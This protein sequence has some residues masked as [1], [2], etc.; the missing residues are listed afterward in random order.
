MIKNLELY[1]GNKGGCDAFG[2]WDDESI[3]LSIS[4]ELKQGTRGLDCLVRKAET[5]NHADLVHAFNNNEAWA[6][7]ED[8]ILCSIEDAKEEEEA[9]ND[10]DAGEQAGEGY[11]G[12]VA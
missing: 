2:L 9:A 8:A 6:T 11:H 4:F 10:E 3:H 7:I 5:A 1:A 12:A